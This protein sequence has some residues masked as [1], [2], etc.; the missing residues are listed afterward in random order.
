MIFRVPWQPGPEDGWTGQALISLTDFTAYETRDVPGVW[1]IGMRLRRSWPG[2]PGAV[3]L[4]L[5]AM[6]HR[7][8]SGSV[9][10]WR[11]EE[12]L[13]RFVNWPVHLD[14]IRENRD[15]G[16]L[17]SAGWHVERFAKAGAWAESRRRIAS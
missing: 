7:R 10:V 14:V 5:W 3:G 8:R 4:W 2:M 12:D 17:V 15:R 6:P 1:R 16:A 11:S 13:M 9:S